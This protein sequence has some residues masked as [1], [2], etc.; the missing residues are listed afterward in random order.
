MSH[1]MAIRE[2][3]RHAGTQFDPQLVTLFCE[4]FAQHA[5]TADPAMTAITTPLHAA[6]NRSVGRSAI[7]AGTAAAAGSWMAAT[8]A[9]DGRARDP[10]LQPTS[11]GETPVAATE[12][13]ARRR[14]M[15]A[16]T[17]TDN[18]PGGSGGGAP[19]SAAG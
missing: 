13:R 9:A 3:R 5:P 11:T 2:L 10:I 16:V 1:E 19:E 17:G 7:A 8:D 14:R 12:R 18:R 4:L 15:K 6:A